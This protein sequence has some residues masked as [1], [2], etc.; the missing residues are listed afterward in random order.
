M[1]QIIDYRMT[2]ANA[3]ENRLSVAVRYRKQSYA[4]V[5]TTYHDFE[6]GKPVVK[7]INSFGY[8]STVKKSAARDKAIKKALMGMIFEYQN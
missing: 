5:I 8:L 7:Y 4:V 6:N 2:I 1:V 3:D